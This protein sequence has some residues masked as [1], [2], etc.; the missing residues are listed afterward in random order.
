[1]HRAETIHRLSW[2][3]L[4]TGIGVGTNI[5]HGSPGV[6]VGAHPTAYG[7]AP[8]AAARPMRTFLAIRVVPPSVGAGHCPFTGVGNNQFA[9]G[10]TSRKKGAGATGAGVVSTGVGT[11]VVGGVGM[12]VK[13]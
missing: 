6:G 1:M 13:A 8:S 11:V 10:G 5:G 3:L 9:G 7:I 12:G 2:G 4:P